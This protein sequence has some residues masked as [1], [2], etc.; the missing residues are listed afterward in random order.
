MVNP[1]NALYLGPFGPLHSPSFYHDAPAVDL[2]CSC[3]LICIT[4]LY[5]CEALLDKRVMSILYNRGQVAIGVE[6]RLALDARGRT[7]GLLL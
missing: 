5:N 3:D 6:S 1:H 2:Q 4:W 7:N